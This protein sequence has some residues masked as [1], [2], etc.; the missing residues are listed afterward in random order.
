MKI[1]ISGSLGN[2]GKPLTEQLVAAGHEVTVISHHKERK[3][4][5]EALGATAAI[6]SVGDAR[7]LTSVFTGADAAFAMT[8]PA[9]GISNIIDNTI[10]VGKAFA[11]AIEQSAIPR[12]VMLSSM[13]ADIPDKNGPIRALYNIEKIYSGMEN[14]SFVFLRA[15]SFYLNFYMNIPMIKNM[16]IIGTNLP[17]NMKFPLA[18]PEDIAT[19]AAQLLQ[20]KF[21]GKQVHYIVSDIRTPDEI[22]KALG[23][24]IGNTELRWVEFTDEQTLQ[25]MKQA[26]LPEELAGLLTEMNAGY[27]SSRLFKDFETKG[28]P[29]NGRVKLEDFAK[30]FAKRF[31]KV[32]VS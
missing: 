1:I 8:P 9:S 18:H 5:I 15:G 7:F 10:N 2:V 32:P 19:A 16:G 13:G 22:A 14:T 12:V 25:G 6:G 26:G 11:T 29:V 23:T 20:S 24:A 21:S 30:E 27:R 3:A 31:D 4:D 28:S 17:G